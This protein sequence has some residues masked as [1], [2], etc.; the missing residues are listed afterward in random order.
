MIRRLLRPWWVRW[1]VAP[2]AVFFSAHAGYTLALKREFERRIEKLRAAGEPV[3]LKDL[4]RPRIPDADNAAA[5]WEEAAAWHEANLHLPTVLL[6]DRPEEEWD[7]GDREAVAAYLDGD[8]YIDLLAR[9]AAKPGMW[10]DLAWEEGLAMPVPVHLQFLDA[11]TYLSHRARFTDRAPD[12]LRCA[13]I[14][15]G[16]ARKVEHSILMGTLIGW[17]VEGAAAESLEQTSRKTG[18]DAREARALLDARL[19]PG[20]GPAHLRETIQAERV[21]G[22]ALVRRWIAGEDPVRVAETLAGTSLEGVEWTL[23]GAIAGSWIA[24][25]LAYRDALRLL[26]LTERSLRLVDLPPR[27]AL[28]RAED[29]AREYGSRSLARLFSAMFA[30]SPANAMMRRLQLEARMRV[31]RVGLALLEVR[32]TTGAWPPSLDAVVPLV[33]EA[34]IEDPYTG[35]RLRYE[36]GVRLQAAAP[37]PEAFKDEPEEYEI[38]WRFQG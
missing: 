19:A 18:F 17:A 27:D 31:A 4:R 16:L 11:K 3:D 7:E 5:L 10:Q 24:R 32:Q 21:Q 15:L 33:G 35:E 37:V 23:G 36:P 13:A 14:M 6:Y 29:L 38:V 12:A 8:T 28:P 34:W 26:D 1:I 25:P 9:A 2:L 20:E 22:L 30:H